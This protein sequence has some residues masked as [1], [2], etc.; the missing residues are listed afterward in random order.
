MELDNVVKIASTKN[1][2]ILN[3]GLE[4]YIKKL[5]GSH[6][7]LNKTIVDNIIPYKDRVAKNFKNSE[8][9][10]KINKTFPSIEIEDILINLE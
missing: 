9:W 10:K 6:Y 2:D 7:K 1:N 8:M 3:Q 5:F 4:S